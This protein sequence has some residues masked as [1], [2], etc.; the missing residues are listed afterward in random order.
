MIE[1]LTDSMKMFRMGLEGGKRSDGKPGVQPEWFYKG[2]GSILRGL[3]TAAG[4]ARFF[5]GRRRGAGDRGALRDCRRRNAYR[6]GFALGNEF[7]DH[8]MER[9]NYLWLAHS[10]LRQCSVGPAMLTR[11]V[12]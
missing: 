11:R 6:L 4:D 9:Q 10:K 3:W 5:A 8:V 1:S 12:A 7:S 2:N